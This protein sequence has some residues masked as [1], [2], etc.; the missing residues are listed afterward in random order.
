MCIR[1]SGDGAQRHVQ[2]SFNRVTHTAVIDLIDSQVV[3]G[4]EGGRIGLVSDDANRPG[5]RACSVERALG[6]LQ[7]FNAGDVIDMNIEDPVDGRDRLLV[8]VHAHRR[9]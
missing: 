2:E 6:T 5:F 3:A 9:Q 1:D 4:C 7:G 8:E